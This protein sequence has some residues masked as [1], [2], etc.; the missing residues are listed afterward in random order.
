L[1]HHLLGK[2]S[3]VVNPGDGFPFQVVELR[4]WL[5]LPRQSRAWNDQENNQDWYAEFHK[6][7]PGVN[8]EELVHLDD[9][10]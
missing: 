10:S 1:I 3:Q 6:E 9:R 4:V 8:P 2:D 5:K 7:L